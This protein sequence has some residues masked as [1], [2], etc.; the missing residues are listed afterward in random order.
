MNQQ[1]GYKLEP[2]LEAWAD[3]V[4]KIWAEKI[5]Q[6]KVYDTGELLDSLHNFMVVNA[7]NDGAKIEFSFKLYGIFVDMG[8]GKEIY[9]GNDGDIGFTPV[10]KA[11]M[12]YSKKFYGQ[13][14]KLKEILMEK[15]SQQFADTLMY[16]FQPSDDF[17][18]SKSKKK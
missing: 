6:L 14:M 17:K 16:A 8:V 5:S 1:N 2:T 15:Y 4:I 10:R 18:P 11:K 7:G 13:V 3:I 12:W 9:K